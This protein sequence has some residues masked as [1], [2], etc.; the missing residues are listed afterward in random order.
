MDLPFPSFSAGA[1]EGLYLLSLGGGQGGDY[2]FPLTDEDT[3]DQMN[4]E[5]VVK[6][7]EQGNRFLVVWSW[8]PTWLT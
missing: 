5:G 2:G 3:K 8:I 7:S 6:I 1:W 4:K